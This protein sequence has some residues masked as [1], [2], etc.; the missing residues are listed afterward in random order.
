MLVVALLAATTGKVPLLSPPVKAVVSFVFPSLGG[1]GNSGSSDASF[2]GDDDDG[3]GR[4]LRA[5]RL[6]SIALRN[7]TSD[8]DEVRGSCGI[9]C[10]SFPSRKREGEE[11]RR[12]EKRDSADLPPKRNSKMSITMPLLLLPHTHTQ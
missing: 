5:S 8:Y 1:G 4:G 6:L 3:N 10:C 9:G 11:R 7:A 2:R 12:N